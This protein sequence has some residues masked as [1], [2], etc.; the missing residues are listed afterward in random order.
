[1]SAVFSRP[2]ARTPTKIA[3]SSA[4]APR[5][6]FFSADATLANLL[7]APWHIFSTV[8]MK[9]PA[10]LIDQLTSA[11]DRGGRHS[12]ARR[13]ASCRIGALLIDI[14][15][16]VD[17]H[18]IGNHH[19]AIRPIA[20]FIDV[21]AHRDIGVGEID[22]AGNIPGWVVTLVGN[23]DA[24]GNVGILV[25]RDPREERLWRTGCLNIYDPTL[26]SCIVGGR[27]NVTAVAVGPRENDRNS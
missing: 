20:G 4:D 24:V 21:T 13:L 22:A 3:N 9:R 16:A 18:G 7:R 10:P 15:G 27:V 19:K 12:Q 6:S 2:N 5:S 11:R 25:D 8:D 14:A 23:I 1:M 17:E 26:S